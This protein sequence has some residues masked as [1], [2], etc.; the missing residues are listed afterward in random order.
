MGRVRFRLQGFVILRLE[1]YCKA[2]TIYKWSLEVLKDRSRK[3]TIISKYRSRKQTNPNKIAWSMEV[4]PAS[5]LFF[6]AER[7]HVGG[8][9]QKS[10]CDTRIRA[11]QYN[12]A[13]LAC[14]WTLPWKNVNPCLLPR[15][16][17]SPPQMYILVEW[18]DSSEHVCET[19]GEHD[20]ICSSLC[21][22]IRSHGQNWIW[23]A[24][25]NSGTR[26]VNQLAFLL[27]KCVSYPPWDLV[28]HEQRL[29][30]D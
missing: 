25:Q 23:R 18:P 1:N 16:M 7:K 28:L 17:S 5:S 27:H 12:W 24:H 19:W 4:L 15:C 21:H 9:T 3:Q 22:W 20:N 13:L 6:Q 14:L 29:F 2:C 10:M 30:P 11:K 26:L 8:F